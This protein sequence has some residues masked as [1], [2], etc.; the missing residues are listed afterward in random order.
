MR[1]IAI[2]HE[3]LVIPG[4]SERI[5]NIFCQLFPNADIFSLVYNENTIGNYL[6][7]RKV[8]T[9]FI[10]KLP[11]GIK[12]YQAYLPLMPIAIEQFD[13]SK[14]DL[15]ISSSSCVA[16]GVITGANTLHICYCHTPM[17]YAWDMYNVYLDQNNIKGIKKA[18]VTIIM[19]YLRMWDRLSADRV[20]HFIA[21][22]NTVKNRIAKHYKKDATVI[23]PPVNTDFYNISD[24]QEDYFLVVSRLVPYKRIDLAVETFNELNLPL[25]IIGDGSEYK[26]LKSCARSNIK[27]LGRLSDEEIRCY[28][29]KC[30]AFI[31]PGE[32]DFGITPLEAM[33]SGKPVIAYRAGGVRETVVEGKTGL[34]FDKQSKESLMETVKNF[35]SIEDSFKKHDIRNHALKFNEERFKREI[36]SF[37]EEKYMDFK[38]KIGG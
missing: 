10:Q 30:R 19:N 24:E 9:S 29:S 25:F 17:R 7:G 3:W 11:L 4:G 6:N 20:D 21:N 22:S 33:A 18:L 37:I 36:L 13:L 14:Y 35:I 27:F 34:F 26:K 2:V 31:F 23:Y 38:K 5:I 28:Y 32:E 15:V 1:K 12:K 16:K 8:N